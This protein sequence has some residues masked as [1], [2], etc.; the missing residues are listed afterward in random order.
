MKTNENKKE[1][2]KRKIILVVLLLLILLIL[3]LLFRNKVEWKIDYID[4]IKYNHYVTSLDINKKNKF[5]STYEFEVSSNDESEIGYKI[6]LTSE[7]NLSKLQNEDILISIKKNGKYIV[8]SKNKGELLANLEGFNLESSSGYYN[9]SSDV[10]KGKDKD[11]FEI[12]I[13]LDKKENKRSDKE[14]SFDVKVYKTKSEEVSKIKVELDAQGGT[15]DVKEISIFENGVYGKLPEPI[16]DGY[17]FIGWYTE[18]ENGTPVSSTDYYKNIKATKL[19]ARY[20]KNK[21]KVTIQTNGGKYDGSIVTYVDYNEEI[22][23]GSITKVGYTFTK[24]QSNVNIKDNKFNVTSDVT[25]SA[26]WKANKYMLTIDPDNDTKTESME[27]EYL[28]TKK[29]NTPTK[30]GYTFNGW[31]LEGAGS[32]N[33]GVFKSGLG[34]SK[35]KATWK[36]NTY[37]VKFDLNGGTANIDTRYI[38]H[39]DSIGELIKPTKKGYTFDGW[40][41]DKKQVT[42]DTK[43]TKDVIVKAEYTKN[44]YKL[45]IDYNDEETDKKYVNIKY[46]ESTKVKDPSRD[47]YLF[48][49]WEITGS[50]YKF[51]NNTFTIGSEDVTIKAKWIKDDF[52]Y[53]VKHYKQNVDGKTYTLVDTDSFYNVKSETEVSG[54]PRDFDG[55]STP[56]VKKIKISTNNEKNV[57]EYKYDRLKY[58]LVIDPN[59]GIYDGNDGINTKTGIR[60]EQELTINKPTKEGYIFKGWEKTGTGI[61]STLVDTATFKMLNGDNILKATWE[62]NT[63][64]IVLD[65][66]GGII[67]TGGKQIK[68]DS[69]YG[70]L[71]TPTKEGYTFNGWFT[72]KNGGTKVNSDDVFKSTKDVTLYAQWTIKTYKLT[73]NPN[74]GTYNTSDEIQY[75]DLNYNQDMT[76]LKP[77]RTGYTFVSWTLEG[78]G[79]MTSFTDEATFTMKTSDSVLNAIWQVNTYTITL[80]PNGGIVTTNILEKEYGNKYGALEIPIK[81]GFVFDG[82]YDGEELID[83]NSL[84]RKNTTLKAK[85]SPK[86]TTLTIKYNDGVKQDTIKNA[87]FNESIKI[88]IPERLGYTFAGWILVSGNSDLS[89]SLVQEALVIM[90]SEDT[91]IEAT[92]TPNKYKVIYETNGGKLDN[93]I[94]DTTYD[95]T[96]D[97][98]TPTKE[99]YTFLGWYFENTYENRL[100]ENTIMNKTYEHTLY[101]S[102]QANTYTITYDYDGGEG[103]PKSMDVKY[104]TSIGKLPIATKEGNTF[105]GWYYKENLITDDLVYNYS[106]NITIVAKWQVLSYELEINPNGGTYD[107]FVA[108]IKKIYNYNSLVEIKTPTR[109]GYVFD[110]WDIS[111]PSVLIDNKLTIKNGNTKIIA[112]WKEYAGKL[113]IKYNDDITADKVIDNLAYKSTYQISDPVRDG[114]TFTGWKLVGVDARLSEKTFIMGTTDATLTASWTPNTYTYIVKHYQGTNDGKYTLVGADTKEDESLFGTEV[115]PEVKTYEGFTSPSTKTITI[116]SNREQNTI[117]YYYERNKYKLTINPNGGL[118]NDSDSTIEKEVYYEDKIGLAIPTKTGYTFTNWTIDNATIIDNQITI[119]TKDVNIIANYEANM[120]MLIYNTNG[121]GISV[122]GKIITYGEKIGELPIP[123]KAGYNF[124]GWYSDSEYKNKITEDDVFTFTSHTT[125]YAKWVKCDYKLTIDPN[126]GEYNNT[127]NPTILGINLGQTISVEKPVKY[128]YDFAGWTISGPGVLSSLVEAGTFTAGEGNTTITAIWSPKKYTLYY[129]ANGG[130]VNPLS[131]EI[132]FNEKYGTLDVPTKNGYT[133]NGWYTDIEDG[134]IVDENVLLTTEG[135]KHIFAHWTLNSY[136]L[137]VDPNGGKWIDNDEEITDKKEFTLE[138]LSTKE[139]KAPTRVGY[140]FNTWKYVGD[141]AG[142]NMNTMISDATFTMGYKDL[143]LQADWIANSY[144]IVFDAQ[145]GNATSNNK[146][147]TYDEVYGALPTSTKE[148]YTFDGWYTDKENGTKILDTDIVRVTDTTVLYARYIANEYIATYEANGG[149]LNESSKTVTFNSKYGELDTPSK[150]GYTFDGWFLDETLTKKVDNDSLVTIPNHHTLYAKW[151]ANKYKVTFD[152]NGGKNLEISDKLVTY[153]SEYGILPNVTK[154]GF[155][156]IGWFTTKNEDGEQIRVDDIVKIVDD[157]TV[158]AHYSYIDYNLMFNTNGGEPLNDKVVHYTAKY[159]ELPIPVKSGYAFDGWFLDSALSEKVDADTIVKT[160]GNHTIY[161][162]WEIEK[163]RVV[164]DTDGGS[165][166]SSKEVTFGKKYGTLETPTKDNYVFTGW[167]LDVSHTVQVYDTTIVTATSNHTLYAGWVSKL[168]SPEY[169]LQSG[170]WKEFPKTSSTITGNYVVKENITITGANDTAAITVSGTAIIYIPKGV[171]LTLT[172]GK[173]V[174][175]GAG[176][177]INLTSGNELIILGEGTLNATGGKAGNGESGIYG[178]QGSVSSSFYGGWG[179][180]GGDGG[181]GAGAGIGTNGGIGG[182]GGSTVFSNSTSNQIATTNAKNGNSGSNGKSSATA[183]TLKVLGNVTI[184]A[185]AGTKGNGGAGG[186]A[187]S[188]APYKSLGSYTKAAAG[189][190]GGGGGGGAG[191]AGV[192]IGAGGPGGGGGGSGATGRYVSSTLYVFFHG[193]GGKYGKGAS[194]GTNGAMSTYKGP[195]AVYTDNI[196]IGGSGGSGGSYGGNGTMYKASVS[197]VNG[198]TSYTT[199]ETDAKLKYTIIFNGQMSDTTGTQSQTVL[200]GSKLSS[201]TIPTR[202]GYKFDGYYLG[203]NGL[204]TKYIDENGEP[205]SIYYRA[206]NITLYANWIEE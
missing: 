195:G 191:Y 118:Y 172:G 72:E 180:A 126:D 117:E 93:L 203:I 56:E 57:I 3:F 10:I 148:G 109:V 43:V 182:A 181:G 107:G 151:T 33:N 197:T 38:N 124:D 68:Y 204:G 134:D 179:A 54:V 77:V 100:D 23:L 199:A 104:D 144:I 164:F 155:N 70:A 94:K 176:A 125:L 9:L 19:Y 114:Y 24:W 73:I 202:E 13:W 80:E 120:Y 28:K 138:Y 52:S 79:S 11:K 140:R 154:D 136:V 166:I 36:I 75:F 132:I 198:R 206:E 141:Q 112:K 95:T 63:Y 71:E 39:N 32:I 59:G 122:G 12:K 184:N 44:T 108:S 156:F 131:K 66:N 185:T 25:I 130:I 98:P 193:G 20:E 137:T 103:T 82:W 157:I 2:N 49:G 99:G 50:D 200:Y 34:S 161:A 55:F 41:I 78:N 16:K 90:G 84:V 123:T 26:I 165:T 76:I 146:T 48:A 178:W 30:E 86:D 37:T 163:Y 91:T 64:N 119:G 187:P 42:K 153:D 106:E 61:M 160:L 135:N 129:S 4:G 7:D 121:G 189:N 194:N 51:E 162:K 83:E 8:G 21:Y 40:Y 113:T 101:A 127:T 110:G 47:N 74:G 205:T 92:W 170:E 115:T 29:I 17:K 139:I 67:T 65:P 87:K 169:S 167:Y 186:G 6:Y 15:T 173:S 69:V 105:L 152:A 168:L 175:Y 96:Y 81:N 159:G 22:T 88:D 45:T 143:T 201:I 158:Y 142:A 188:D 116:S 149:T 192:A 85:W 150:T 31:V 196:G 174:N 60:Y 171:T 102:W 177:G 58:K 89:S 97:L 147:V 128:G 183:G 53:I 133:F 111:G 62:A 35:L 27:I 5:K 18:K 145:G 46:L 1:K 190:G 14:Y